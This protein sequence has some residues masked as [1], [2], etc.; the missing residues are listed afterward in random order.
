MA[1][2]IRCPKCLTTMLS[3]GAIERENREREKKA[4][5]E[6]PKQEPEEVKADTE[7]PSNAKKVR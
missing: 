6:K 3:S 1:Q 7:A 4:A 2:F 5:A